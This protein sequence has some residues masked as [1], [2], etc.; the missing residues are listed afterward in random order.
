M[1]YYSSDLCFE[2]LLEVIEIQ[3]IDR[4][5]YCEFKKIS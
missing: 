2:H 5:W 3:L 4:K 1:F